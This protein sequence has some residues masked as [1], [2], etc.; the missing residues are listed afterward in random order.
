MTALK[1]AELSVKAGFPPGV[2][3]ILPGSGQY[4]IYGQKG[5]TMNSKIQS[6]HEASV[7][8]TPFL[9]G[10]F[11]SKTCLCTF[12]KPLSQYQQASG[13]RQ[14]FQMIQESNSQYL[15]QFPVMIRMHFW[16]FLV[17]H[18]RHV[19]LLMHVLFEHF[20]DFEI[21]RRHLKNLP[22]SVYSLATTVTPIVNLT[23]EQVVLQHLRLETSVRIM[24]G[25]SG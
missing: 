23:Q 16:R 7:F 15:R 10:N 21:C 19:W 8:L 22:L 6:I 12:Y 5:F 3:N 4:L 2:I 1:F 18:V 25:V 13:K 11:P 14:G 9:I 17:C 20:K 24:R